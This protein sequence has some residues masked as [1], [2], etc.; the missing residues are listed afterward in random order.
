MGDQERKASA[1]TIGPKEIIKLPLSAIHLNGRKR[2]VN[3]GTAHDLANSIAQIGLINPIVVSNDHYLLT[4]A[5]RLE[6]HRILGHSEIECRVVDFGNDSLEAELFEIDENLIRNDLTALEQGEHLVRRD[7]IL[8]EFG[9]RAQVGG[10]G[11]NQYRSKGEFNSPLH[12]VKLTADLASEIGLSER[13]AQQRKQIA[14]SLTPE[15]RDA[16]RHAPLADKKIDL[17]KIAT[18]KDPERKSRV[19]ELMISDSPPASVKAAVKRYRV[20]VG[21]IE[22]TVDIIRPTNWWGIGRPH[23][24][25][26]PG[27]N[28]SVPGEIYANALYYFAPQK[29]IA[30]DS[31]AGSGML[32]RVYDDRRRWQ[33]DSDFDLDIRLFDKYPREPFATDCD[34]KHHDAAQPLPLM[35]DWIFVDP[36]YFGQS[37]HLFDGE[38]AQTRDYTTYSA[39]ME[40]VITASYQ[41]LNPDGI[42]CLLTNPYITWESDFID[43]PF[44]TSTI[45]RGIGFIPFFSLVINKCEQW[46]SFGGRANNKA[47]RL[48][49]MYSDTSTLLVFKKGIDN[50]I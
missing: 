24:P 8:T 25:Q 33:K 9:V 49:R 32:R 39:L 7:E 38:L 20:E 36:P 41:S 28:G 1:E 13:V 16:I 4:G 45:A 31:M 46:R 40:R 37:S 23:Y 50:V 3:I 12:Y 19:V 26:Q 34:I 11:S 42:L 5:H 10:D 27:F 48:R 44:D 18:I 21:E 35:A 17:L 22:D 14:K 47:K 2:L 15:Q 6:A 43:I 29:G 30:I